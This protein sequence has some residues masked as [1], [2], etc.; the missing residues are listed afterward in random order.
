M[1]YSLLFIVLVALFLAACGASNAPMVKVTVTTEATQPSGTNYDWSGSGSSSDSTSSTS[2]ESSQYQTGKLGDTFVYTL[3]DYELEVTAVRTKWF[4]RSVDE[5]G[6]VNHPKMLG[7]WLKIKNNGPKVYDDSMSNCALML[8][9][10]GGQVDVNYMDTYDANGNEMAM[11]GVRI[12]KG[13]TRAGWVFFK[14]GNK[15]A[16]TFQF[17]PDSGWSETVGEWSL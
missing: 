1:K 3:G 4:Q 11:E 17:T 8:T 9:T 16:D 2:S 6:Y 15:K 5:W 12:T 13:R 14:M 7:V 10:N